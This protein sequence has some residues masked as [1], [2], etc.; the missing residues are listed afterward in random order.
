MI[1]LTQALRQTIGRDNQIIHL[2]L[3]L[4]H[5]SKNPNTLNLKRGYSLIF[6]EIP[7]LMLS[8]GINMK[9]SVGINIKERDN[10]EISKKSLKDNQNPKD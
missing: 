9:E 6:M 4:A 1:S 2:Y 7:K 8:V 3:C 5:R 10:L